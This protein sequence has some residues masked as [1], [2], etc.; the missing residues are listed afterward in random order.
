MKQNAPPET[1]LDARGTTKHISPR[2]EP[3][4]NSK[5]K[6]RFELVPFNTI[7]INTAPDYLIKGIIPRECLAVVWGPPKCGKSFWTFDLVMHIALGRSYRGRKVQQGAVVY[8]ALE[9]VHGFRKRVEA[10]RRRNLS[11]RGE[12]DVPFY[13]LGAS[14][15]LVDDHKALIAAIREQVEP[16]P[17]V[18]V[19]DTFNRAIGGDENNPGDVARFVRAADAIRAAFG[20]A[21]IVV[22][23]CG[24]DG[25]RPRGHTSL[26]AASDVQVAV[27]RD[28]QT[29]VIVSKLERMKDDES[30]AEIVSKLDRVD[31]GTD[32]DGD[33]I[34]SCVILPAEGGARRKVKLS[35]NA[36]LALDALNAP[37]QITAR[38]RQPVITYPNNRT[39][40]R[41]RLRFSEAITTS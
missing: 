26:P 19:I 27:I 28:A 13:L 11:T 22:H 33:P 38:S 31:L 36:Q 5:P 14:L 16:T 15:N 20:C 34:T 7:K 23:H 12:S 3:N 9:G 25:S 30:G 10:W 39:S 18:V 41:V 4:G 29:G 35:D 17:A 40:E 24:H 6:R 37:S 8:L 32:D 2:K 1:H 21:V